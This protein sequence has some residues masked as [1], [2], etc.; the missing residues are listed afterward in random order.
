MSEP[1]ARAVQA[2]LDR[3]PVLTAAVVVEGEPVAAVLPFAVTADGGA[4]LVHVSALA[5]HARGLFDGAPVGIAVHAAVTADRDP[6]QVPRLTVQATARAIEPGAPGFA[7]AAARLVARFPAAATTLRL[8]DFSVYALE[9]G[10][11]RYIE[12]FARAVPVGPATFVR[13]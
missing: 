4:L 13:A 6:M 11:G 9:L 1:T 5:R 8:P 7:A 12:G 10:R 2:L 3:E